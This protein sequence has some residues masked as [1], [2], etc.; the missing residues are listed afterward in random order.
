VARRR[1]FEDRSFRVENSDD[2]SDEPIGRQ[3]DAQVRIHPAEQAGRVRFKRGKRFQRVASER[4]VADR[5]RSD[6]ADVPEDDL[7]SAVGEMDEVVEVT[8]DGPPAR[9]GNIVSHQPNARKSRRIF[10]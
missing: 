4:G 6:A 8:A 5:L 3:M 2:Q 9:G 7:Q 1:V 10:G